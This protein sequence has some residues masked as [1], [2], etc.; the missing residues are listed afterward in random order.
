[1]VVAPLACLS[2]R[3]SHASPPLPSHSTRDDRAAAYEK[4]VLSLRCQDAIPKTCSEKIR[5]NTLLGEP[6]EPL[7]RDPGCSSGTDFGSAAT[8][9]S[10]GR[11]LASKCTDP[12][13]MRPRWSCQDLVAG[14]R[15]FALLPMEQDSC[16]SLHSAVGTTPLLRHESQNL[17]FGS[18]S[19]VRSRCS[20]CAD[21]ISLQLS[22][23]QSSNSSLF[24]SSTPMPPHCAM[25]RLAWKTSASGGGDNVRR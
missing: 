1:M 10:A 3:H 4:E 18:S 21:G 13:S 25:K 22:R 17:E 12:N 23:R 20:C 8:T 5:R 15:P 9:F 11:S 2:P 6:G 19:D 7:P 24:S 16:T 14:R